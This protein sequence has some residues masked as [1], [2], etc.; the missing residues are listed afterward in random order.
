M[1]QKAAAL[2]GNLDTQAI[3]NLPVPAGLCSYPAISCP[4]VPGAHALLGLTV[5]NQNMS[6]KKI[7][8]VDDSAVVLKTLELK[9]KAA[10]FNVIT[11]NEGGGAL[12]IIR[13]DRPDLILLDIDF[14]PDVSHGGGIAWNGILIMQWLGRIEEAKDIPIIIITG[15]D[16][17]KYRSQAMKLGARGFFSKPVNH[18]ALSQ[19]IR[20]T[21]DQIAPSA[22]AA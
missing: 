19:A 3:S 13:R 15:Q 6:A 20:K 10:G 7:L 2:Y 16:P 1:P 14:P 4:G 11:A 12:T 5:T 22:A 9:L 21:L 17:E 8:V 18:E